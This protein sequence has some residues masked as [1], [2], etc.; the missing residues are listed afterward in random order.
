MGSDGK[1]L[2]KQETIQKKIFVSYGVNIKKHKKSGTSSSI[3][4]AIDTIIQ[5][6]SNQHNVCNSEESIGNFSILS[7]I[8][9]A[10]GLNPEVASIGSFEQTKETRLWRTLLLCIILSQSLKKCPNCLKVY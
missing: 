2:K 7:E 4:P 9:L 8:R 10:V 5:T 1:S 6:W 3:D